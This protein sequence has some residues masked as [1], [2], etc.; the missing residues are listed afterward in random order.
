[1]GID[2]YGYNFGDAYGDDCYN[3][4]GFN[5]GGRFDDYYDGYNGMSSGMDMG[6]R[7]GRMVRGGSMMDSP[8]RGVG[9]GQGIRSSSMGRG[10]R[11]QSFGGQ[12][13]SFRGNGTLGSARGRAGGLKRKQPDGL[14]NPNAKRGGMYGGGA[15][16]GAS[17]W[18]YG[19]APSAQQDWTS[20]TFA[21]NSFM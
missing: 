18:S 4:G 8:G 1:M 19:S 15:G 20:D 14:P 21:E 5:Y 16:Q 6:F 9:Y 13:R 3:N 11:G 10:G 7:G 2:S 17:G 12:S